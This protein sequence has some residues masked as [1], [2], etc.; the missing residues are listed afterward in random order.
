[1]GIVQEK[2][3]IIIQML[4]KDNNQLNINWVYYENK[5]TYFQNG[6]KLLV[7]TLDRLGQPRNTKHLLKLANAFCF[8]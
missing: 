4:S 7:K 8:F 5:I 3:E 1:M 6:E 2:C